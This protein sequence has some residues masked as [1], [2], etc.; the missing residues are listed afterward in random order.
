MLKN[1]RTKIAKA[2]APE[3]VAVVLDLEK[4]VSGIEDNVNQRIAKTLIDL[5]PMEL[6][7]KK[8]HGVFGGDFERPEERLNEAGKLGMYMWAYGQRND[9]YFKHMTQWFLDT[10]GNNT[11]RKAKNDHEWFFG[12][13]CII[14]ILSFVKEVGRL[15]NLYEELMEK[16][17]EDKFDG[18][19][20]V[21]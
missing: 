6:V 5:D 4:R 13:A 19:S 3:Y 10:Q 2:I 12:R 14:N 16:R 11:V 9:P 21:E 18:E 7:M 17:G 15:S 20:T 8:Y 1:L